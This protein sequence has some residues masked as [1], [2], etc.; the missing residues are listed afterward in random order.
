MRGSETTVD[1]EGLTPYGGYLS[2]FPICPVEQIN[3]H[4]QAKLSPRICSVCSSSSRMLEFI[5]QMS[6]GSNTGVRVLGLARL[7][8]DVVKRHV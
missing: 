6:I 2:E 1:P 4:R 8:G 5:S 3:I 7:H